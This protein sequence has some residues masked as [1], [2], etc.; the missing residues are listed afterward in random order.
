MHPKHDGILSIIKQCASPRRLWVGA[1]GV[2]A[3]TAVALYTGNLSIWPAMMFL[4]AMLSSQLGV[5]LLRS[6]LLLKW[7]EKN[8]EDISEDS[9]GVPMQLLLLEVAKGCYLITAMA[10]AGLVCMSG[11]WA[12]IPGI[13]LAIVMYFY[14][15]G[16]TPL[17]GSWGEQF[18]QFIFF[19]PVAVFGTF[20][21]QALHC[22]HS[23][24]MVMTDSMPALLSSV[25]IGL[26][27]VNASLIG[28][29]VA[30]DRDEIPNR[31]NFVARLGVKGVSW[32]VIVNGL[33]FYAFEW[34]LLINYQVPHWGLVALIPTLS[35][36]INFVVGIGMRRNSPTILKKMYVIAIQ[37]PFLYS[38]LALIVLL[39]LREP[40]H[41]GFI[42]FG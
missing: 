37:N 20:F 30:D 12:L 2:I 39:I 28:K 31:K 19:G 23:F 6:R 22:W 8:T 26:L 41:G 1:S 9:N 10:I 3:G 38:L 35:F 7:S 14:V 36:L 18:C 11:L 21:Y 25:V 34:V 13:A 29:C 40:G 4:V 27:A 16:P 32:I 17:Y 42:I 24:D 33:I 15:S 5:N